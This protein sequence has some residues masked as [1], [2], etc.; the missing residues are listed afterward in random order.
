MAAMAHP[1][2]KEDTVK[3][4]R[5]PR[6]SP[7]IPPETHPKVYCGARVEWNLSMSPY[8]EKRE[9]GETICPECVRVIT[10]QRKLQGQRIPLHWEE[11]SRR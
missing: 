11:P 1:A 2:K 9:L 5:R 8:L 4:L 7:P 6:W 3:H 10:V